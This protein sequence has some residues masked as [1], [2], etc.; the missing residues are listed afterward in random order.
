MS[1]PKKKI[2]YKD[3]IPIGPPR[4]TAFEKARIIGVRAIQI[5][6]G[7]R[8]FIKVDRPMSSLE[9]AEREVKEGVL[10]LSIKRKRP[11]KEDFEPIPLKWL[12]EAEKEDSIVEL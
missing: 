8:P 4:L 9:I 11:F 1:K 6:Y 7:A 3:L 2:R 5:D 12:M 10:P